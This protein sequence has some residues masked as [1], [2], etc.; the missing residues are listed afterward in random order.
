MRLISWKYNVENKKR[1]DELSL[2]VWIWN[3]YLIFSPIPSISPL[4]VCYLFFHYVLNADISIYNFIFSPFHTI[5]SM[6][7]SQFCSSTISF[8]ELSIPV[9]RGFL[10]F[11][12]LHSI[13]L[14]ESTTNHSASP[15]FMYSGVISSLLLDKIRQQWLTL[16]IRHLFL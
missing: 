9:C 3:I 10:Y 5:S 15:L 13:P 6:L 14:C 1:I 16:N 11:L 2:F 7:Y 12:Q 8:G 4:L